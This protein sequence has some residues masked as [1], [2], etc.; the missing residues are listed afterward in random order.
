MESLQVVHVVVE[1]A[2][3]VAVVKATLAISK[4]EFR[5][6]LMWAEFSRRIGLLEDKD[7]E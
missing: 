5:V 2:I 4:L 1:V 3:L 7:E 6:E